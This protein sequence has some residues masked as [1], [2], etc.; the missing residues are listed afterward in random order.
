MKNNYLLKKYIKFKIKEK[1]FKVQIQFEP[2][3]SNDKN[4]NF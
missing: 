3:L 1:N 2:K 4:Q